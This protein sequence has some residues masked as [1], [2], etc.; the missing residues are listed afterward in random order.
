MQCTDQVNEFAPRGEIRQP[1]WISELM[2][3]YWG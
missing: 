1:E 2:N 3:K